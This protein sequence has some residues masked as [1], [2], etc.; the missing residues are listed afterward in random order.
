MEPA[1]RVTC[2]RRPRPEAL[3]SG[4]F[5][6]WND[7]AAFVG[8][9]YHAGPHERFPASLCLAIGRAFRARFG[10]DAEWDDWRGALIAPNAPQEADMRGT[11]VVI[12]II[13]PE[14]EAYARI[15]HLVGPRRPVHRIPDAVAERLATVAADMLARGRFDVVRL[16]EKCLAA[17]GGTACAPRTIDPRVQRTL[18]ILKSS[19]P[20]V[21]LLSDI[22][23]TVGLSESRLT[24]LFNATMG[25]SLRRYVQWLRLRHAVFHMAVGNSITEA[26]YEAGF[27]D[28]A[29][30]SRTF[31]SMFG[32]PIS[33]F[34]G[35]TTR[36]SWMIELSAEPPLG[37]HAV[38]DRE[39]WELVAR[40]LAPD[41]P[42][43]ARVEPK[44][45]RRGGRRGGFARL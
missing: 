39:R 11:R 27:A 34:F 2:R 3:A 12:L 28:L 9:G 20:D 40:A 42:A 10:R 14:S 22:A 13:D 19:V 7:G 1:E 41:V 43:A 30:L 32:V 25:L 8:G 16:W 31:R 21:P 26:A 15:S 37:P 4:T 18:A 36:V 5:H 23:S 29:H 24:S 45:A 35:R 44:R 33:S 17:V 38:Q 6:L